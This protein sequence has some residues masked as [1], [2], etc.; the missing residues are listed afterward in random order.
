MSADVMEFGD[1]Q[2]V[3]RFGYNALTEASFLLLRIRD[4]RAAAAWLASAPVSNA[5][6]LDKPPQTALQVAFTRQGLEALRVSPTVIAGF[7]DEF[8]SGMWGQENRSRRLGDV[9][10]SA[11]VTWRWGGPER[12]PHVLVMLYAQTG[13]ASFTEAVKGA[14]WEKAFELM[15]SLPTSNLHGFEPFGF[16]DG[17]SQPSLDW[18]QRRTSGDQLAYTNIAC[19]GEFLLGYP[20]EYG[21]YTDRPLLPMDNRNTTL[22]EAEDTPGMRDLGR[23]GTYLVLR[24]LQ[25]DVRGF[26]QFADR[27]AN[28]DQQQRAQLASS[29][30]VARATARLWLRLAAYRYLA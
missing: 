6:K 15:E 12:I 19:L 30:V 7:S 8:L 22:P 28:G 1:V 10:P 13:L 20:N 16:K 11:P 18:E 26:W 27:Q 17:I 5:I 4:A 29:M 9:G 24:Q 21:R 25:Q 14:A 3:M 2:G 23:N